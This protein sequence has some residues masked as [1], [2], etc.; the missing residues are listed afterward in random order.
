MLERL[1]LHSLSAN[2]LF[3]FLASFMQWFVEQICLHSCFEAMMVKKFPHGKQNCYCNQI[4][5]Y[6]LENWDVVHCVPTA[7]I[8]HHQCLNYILECRSLQ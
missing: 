4:Y 6:A 3:D 2:L 8:L 7:N 1:S 5:N